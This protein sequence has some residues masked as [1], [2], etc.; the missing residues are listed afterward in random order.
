MADLFLI[1]F[2]IA[3]V[4]FIGAF[5]TDVEKKGTLIKAFLFICSAGIMYMVVGMTEVP[6]TTT[7]FVYPA[8]QMAVNTVSGS[9]VSNTIQSFPAMNVTQV[10]NPISSSIVYDLNWLYIIYLIICLLFAVFAIL[11]EGVNTQQR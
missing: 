4:F 8:Y 10:D 11:T 6:T 9:T 2:S 5:F 1:P 3:I 7:N